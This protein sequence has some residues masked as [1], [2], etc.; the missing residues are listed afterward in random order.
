MGEEDPIYM[1][2][3]TNEESLYVQIKSMR[4]P[5]INRHSIE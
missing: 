4:V 5:F 2:P 1:T 3:A